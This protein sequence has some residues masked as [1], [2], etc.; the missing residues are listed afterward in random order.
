MLKLS[1]LSDG[2]LSF[3]FL[4][5]VISFS[6]LLFG[7]FYIFDL[8]EELSESGTGTVVFRTPRTVQSSV[9]S[10]RNSLV[11]FLFPLKCLNE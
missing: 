6:H 8:Q 2:S 9:V 10:D 5:I 7:Q 3:Y 4:Y 1:D 11:V